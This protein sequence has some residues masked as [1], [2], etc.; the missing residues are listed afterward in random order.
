MNLVVLKNSIFELNLFINFWVRWRVVEIRRGKIYFL[1][2]SKNGR[3]KVKGRG[4]LGIM[5]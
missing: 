3:K 1:E 5:R 2:G 4:F